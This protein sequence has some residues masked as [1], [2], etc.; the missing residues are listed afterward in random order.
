MPAFDDGKLAYYGPV[1][2]VG[3][4]EVECPGAHAEPLAALSYF[5]RHA[6]HQ[7]PPLRPSSLGQGRALRCGEQALSLNQGLRR[8]SRVEPPERAPETPC[9]DNVSV[10]RPLSFGLSR[11]DLWAD[12]VRVALIAKPGNRS[13]FHVVFNEL[14]HSDS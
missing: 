6:P 8:K 12:K 4:V 9:E 3:V 7:H 5:D 10:A 1:V 2:A 11:R 14:F 13:A